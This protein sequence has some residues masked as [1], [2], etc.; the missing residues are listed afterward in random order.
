MLTIPARKTGARWTAQGFREAVGALADG[1][2][3]VSVMPRKAKR[4]MQANRR[5]WALLTVAAEELGYD[6]VEELHEGIAM[7]LLRLPELVPGVPR[8]RRTPSLN[9]AEF[10]EYTDAVERF[11]QMEL[12]V[13]LTGWEQVEASV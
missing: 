10:K 1:D 2:Y 8:R 3:I 9:S 12:G 11:L 13:D 4:S 5:Y 7:H 6:S